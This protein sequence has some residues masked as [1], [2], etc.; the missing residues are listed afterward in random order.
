MRHLVHNLGLVLALAL[1]TCLACG[2]VPTG[3]PPFSSST[4][5]GGPEAIDLANLNV[6][7]DIPVLSKPG[8]GTNFTYDLNYDTSVWYPVGSSG[9][10]VWTPVYNWGWRAITEISTGYV[11][12]QGSYTLCT[13]Y[14]GRVE[15]QG[16]EKWTFFNYVYHDPWGIPHPFSGSVIYYL[17]LDPG[18]SCT[19]GSNQG[20]TNSETTDGSG[21]ILNVPASSSGGGG[22]VTHRNGKVVSPPYGTG[23]GAAQ[24]VDRNGNIIS[25][26]S[27]GEFFDTLSSSSA[28]LT[29]AGSGTPSSPSTFT[30][31]VAGGSGSAVYTMKYETLNV[32]TNFG[33]GGIADYGT[34]GT[35]T[36]NLV[37]EI[38]L[39]DYSA[40][41]ASKYTFSY[42]KTPGYSGYYTGRL[43]SVTLPTG[44]TINYVYTGGSSGNITCAD[45]STPGL[46]RTTP[47]TGSKYWNYSRKAESGAAYITTVTD[48]SSQANQTI[49][50]FQGLYETQRDVYSGSAPSF[51]TFPIPESTLQT[52]NLLEETQTCY[53]TSTTSCT[54]TAITL[55]ISQQTVTPILST[56]TSSWS[57]A[58]TAQ[59]IHKYNG[60]GVLT[61]QDDY[62]YG[63]GAVG[64]LLAKTTI[65]YA[66]LTNITEFRQQVTIA[67]SSG[68]FS[69]T[70][71]NY[72]N[73]VTTSSGTPQHTSPLGSRGNLLSVN[74]YTTSSTYLT[75]SFTYYDTGMVSTATDVNGGVTTYNFPNAT[76]TCGN[77]FPTGITEAITSLTQSYTWNCSGGVQ[78]SLADENSQPT[79]TTYSDPY[80]WRPSAA[81]DA[82][83]NET[84]FGYLT[85]MLGWNS[86]LIFNNNN[87]VVNTG[88]GLDGLGRLI[89]LN[90]SKGSS[91]W[92]METQSYDSNGRP[93]AVSLPCQSTGP[94][95]CPTTGQTTTTYDALNRVS[96][97]TAGDGGTASYSYTNNDVLVTISGTGDTTKKRQLEYNGLGQ[98]TSVCEITTTLPGNGPCGQATSAN[99][100][101]TKYTYTPLGQITLVT[102]NDQP[103]GSPQSRTY[104]YDWMGRLT[105]ETNPESGTTQY[106]YDTFPSSCYNFG[107]NQSGNLTGKT[108]ANGNTNCFHYDALHRLLDL[109]STGSTNN[110]CKRLRY[111]VATNGVDGSAPSQIG[112]SNLTYIASR[113]ME[114]E[115]DTCGAWPP[116][117]AT[118][119]TDEWFAYDKDGRTTNLWEHTPNSGSGYY[120]P[121]VASY[122]PSG[123]LDTLSGVPGLPTITYTPDY[124]GRV[125]TVT[126]SSG[127]NPVVLSGSNPGTAYNPASQVTQ[128]NFGSGNSD[129]FTYDP[130]TG[131]ITQYA[132][133]VGGQTES[134]TLTWNGTGTL[135]GLVTADPFYSNNAQTC[136]YAH[137]DLM[138]ISSANCSSN[139]AFSQNFSYDA[140]GNIS[141]SGTAA[142]QPSYSTKLTN[143]ISQLGSCTPSYDSDGHVLN[144]CLHTFTWDVFGLPASMDGVT[145]TYDALGRM[146]ERNNAGTITQVTY[147][148]AG[149]KLGIMSGKT[150]NQG[151]V[152]LPAGAVAQYQANGGFYYR[153]PDWQ[154]SAR[155]VTQEGTPWVYYDGS[156]SPFGYP[157]AIYNSSDFSFTGM[158]MDTSTN[159][160]D[161]PAREYEFQGR[162]VSPDPPG[163]ASVDPTHPQ[164]WNRYAYV[165]NN[166]L[167]SV[168]PT[169]LDQSSDCVWYG[170]CSGLFGPG[171][172]GGANYGGGP[173][174]CT[175]DGAPVSCGSLTGV[176]GL[177]SNGIAACPGPC[178]GFNSS[179]QFV[180][181]VAGAGGATGYVSLS[182]IL[183][184]IYEWNG[185][186]YSAG[187]F[188]D[189]VID[190]NVEIQREALAEAI[191][192]AS[193]SAD[194]SNWDAI[195]NGLNP[196]NVS[197]SLQIQ[198]G[199][200]DFSWE[201][202]PGLLNF[203]P[204]A[205][206]LKGGC[207]LACRY[208]NMGAIHFNNNMFH[209]DTA[210][211]TWGFGFGLLMHGFGD[212]FL[213]NIN[214]GV[215]MVP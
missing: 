207:E 10:Q 58:K 86:T 199:N 173:D 11:S 184:G 88:T 78:T 101:L 214:P 203:L 47:D 95:S 139:P 25:V 111:D 142:F 148:P 150:L 147:T 44:G 177:G 131:R 17:P 5:S 66:T 108:D 4:S 87:T 138:R 130:N 82:L 185:A 94:W 1:L 121:I 40:N 45:G 161:F 55:P 213:G 92:D 171:G 191:S 156:Y 49:I 38:D 51:T 125:N 151:Y 201:G 93:Y 117:S 206:W 170:D 137:D 178:S 19:V 77:A 146:V 175:L 14:V 3:T 15:Y 127:Q 192:L 69:Q 89:A 80:F 21:L 120:Y 211:P 145:L 122:W 128:I 193:N 194:G 54:N 81:T 133:N 110:Y 28:V 144:D 162:W 116:T 13:Y 96:Q 104:A 75:Q 143:Q 79:T 22:T 34:N 204:S 129:S 107:D 140:F 160:Y 85:P 105:S 57:S 56:G 126:A 153:N 102:Q 114:A 9:N 164:S 84:T 98:L 16:Y 208:G 26:N 154:G 167:A 42:E 168:D 181:F 99:G 29:V 91:L 65:T 186:F 106:A 59:H 68:T 198:G 158:N 12:M 48:P 112:T 103:N 196:Y 67:N 43:A 200:V 97:I 205:A 39:P 18:G 210:S 172:G 27:S 132:F 182:N 141:V 63:N 187:Q 152:P 46:Q 62:D 50:Q 113:L 7:F 135:G 215:P 83:N 60:N 124:E 41:N 155:L 61:E 8:R 23:T 100:Y 30:Y 134:G 195:Y 123:L 20:I 118:M 53:N 70:S 179:G 119:L 149:A 189:Q 76:S 115:T 212:V 197:G 36:A 188:N 109:G 52:S 183:Q 166:P 72:G 163:L 209:L 202:D 159:L 32:R 165:T 136:T 6:H 2:Q 174:G 71:Y 90:H 180:Q 35:T 157:Y 190:P 64:S 176:G 74:Y 73:T 31:P 37:S 33:C 169:G 24:F